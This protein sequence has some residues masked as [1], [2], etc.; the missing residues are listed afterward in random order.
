MPRH[1]EKAQ[2]Y[3]FGEALDQLNYLVFLFVPKIYAVFNPQEE[4]EKQ[5][6]RRTTYGS[7]FVSKDN[8]PTPVSKER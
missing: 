8:V 5:G 6:V 1:L 2:I 4:K 3:A 7:V